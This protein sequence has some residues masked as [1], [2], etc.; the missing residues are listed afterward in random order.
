MGVRQNS[1]GQDEPSR[2]KERLVAKG[3]SKKED[4]DY[5][6]FF[7]PVCRYSTVRFLFSISV[8]YGWNRVQRDV[9]TAFL[10]AS[11]D[12]EI[13]VTQAEGYVKEGFENFVFKLHKELYGLKQASRLWNK[14][15]ESFL[16]DRGFDSSWADPSLFFNSKNGCIVIV[17]VYVDDLLVTGNS[18]CL[19]QTSPPR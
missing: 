19:E 2:Y 15:L 10:N 6:D 4:V 3:F 12:E 1:D 18:C 7:P 9:K 14:L 16:T 13:Y 8:Q 17:V 5:F 11:L